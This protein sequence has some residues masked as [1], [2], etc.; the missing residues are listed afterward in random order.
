MRFSVA[1]YLFAPPGLCGAQTAS[2]RLIED[3]QIPLFLSDADMRTGVR[4][5]SE[6][7]GVPVDR[8]LTGYFAGPVVAGLLLCS[9]A[10]V[11]GRSQQAN[12]RPGRVRLAGA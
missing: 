4:V 3:G 7:G 5:P 12:E 8:R 6:P 10:G 1:R 11:D 9:Y 2:G